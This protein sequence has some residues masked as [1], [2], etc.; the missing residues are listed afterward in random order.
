VARLPVVES[1]GQPVI[2]E[3]DCVQIVESMRSAHEDISEIGFVI[4]EAKGLICLFYKWLISHVKREGNQV[5][6]ALA[7]LA[8]RSKLSEAW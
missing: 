3:T 8:R 5:A 6:N 1:A 7:C 4:E 2:V